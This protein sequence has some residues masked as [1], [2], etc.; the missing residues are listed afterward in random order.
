MCTLSWRQDG[1]TLDVFFNRDEQKSRVAARPAHFWPDYQAIFPVDPQGGGTWLAVTT[2]GC[3]LALLNNYQASAA[4]EGYS[5]EHSTQSLLS[6]GLVITMLLQE[7]QARSSFDTLATTT[8][9]SAQASAIGHCLRS[10]P[11]CAFQPFT[12]VCLSPGKS[13]QAFDWDGQQLTTFQ[14]ASPV[15]SSAVELA[16]VRAQRIEAYPGNDALVSQLLQYHGSHLPTPGA[17]SVCMHRD[18]AHTVSFS[19]LQVKPLNIRFL[20]RAGAPCQKAQAELHDASATVEVT[21]PRYSDNESPKN[22]FSC[23]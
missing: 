7:L 2:A 1:S 14:P 18:D 4:R 15:I 6:R 10:L 8:C 12:L 23:L 13:A 11:L 19:H 16:N 22:S 3:V 9:S 20:Y 21:V 5:T 17:F